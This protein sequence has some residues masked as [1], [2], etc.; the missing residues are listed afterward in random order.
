[1]SISIFSDFDT[2]RRNYAY[3]SKH[4]EPD[5]L[6]PLVVKTDTGEKDAKLYPKIHIPILQSV[7]VR[8]LPSDLARENVLEETIKRERA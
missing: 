6:R 5:A 3:V 1:M 7:R 8:W 2:F 4:I